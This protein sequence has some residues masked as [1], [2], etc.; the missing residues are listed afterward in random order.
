MVT[1]SQLLDNIVVLD[2]TTIVSGG[3]TTSVLADFGA[4]VIKVEHRR[5]E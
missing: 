3:T 4:Q 1:D 5:R 2:L